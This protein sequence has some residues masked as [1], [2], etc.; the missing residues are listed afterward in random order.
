MN[1]AERSAHIATET[2]LSRA[3]ANDAVTAVFSTIADTLASGETVRIAGFDT[4]LTRSRPAR[5]GRTPVPEK[6]SPS[7]P[8][9][10]LPARPATPLA[11][12]STS[13]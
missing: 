5:Q 1:K 3:G 10:R 4:F 2:S 6:T 12:P 8:R 9:T 7:R 13:G 11:T